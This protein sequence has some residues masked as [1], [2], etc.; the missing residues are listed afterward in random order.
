M[1]VQV[2]FISYRYLPTGSSQTLGGADPRRAARVRGQAIRY[3]WLFPSGPLPRQS[4]HATE[5]HFQLHHRR[6]HG[7]ERVLAGRGRRDFNLQFSIG[8]SEEQRGV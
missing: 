4:G 1:F 5:R 2:S 3:G 7:G 8:F 6:D